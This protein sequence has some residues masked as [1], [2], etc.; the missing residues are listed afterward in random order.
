MNLFLDGAQ[1][2]LAQ[3]LHESSDINSAVTQLQPRQDAEQSENDQDQP[4]SPVTFLWLVFEQV[5]NVVAAFARRSVIGQSQ[6]RRAADR[7][8]FWLGFAFW[9]FGRNLEIQERRTADGTL[10]P[11]FLNRRFG[12]VLGSG[13]GRVLAAILRLERNY[14]F[15]RGALGFNVEVA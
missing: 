12:S 7:L 3:A 9:A 14:L 15:G 1:F 5:I 8:L 10:R 6:K 13:W 4:Q 11:R 2:G